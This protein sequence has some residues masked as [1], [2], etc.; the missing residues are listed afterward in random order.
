[1]I[2]IDLLSIIYLKLKHHI[3][4]HEF[5]F[6]RQFVVIIQVHLWLVEMNYI[7]GS[8]FEFIA[9]TQNLL[10]AVLGQL[11]LFENS[12][13]ELSRLKALLTYCHV[14]GGQQLTACGGIVKV[15]EYVHAWESPVI[16][17][18]VVGLI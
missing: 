17:E 11:L 13:V 6:Q 2:D 5:T 7:F 16:V 8:V 18:G 9:H 10:A 14:V 12:D 3:P 4:I 1:M 15:V